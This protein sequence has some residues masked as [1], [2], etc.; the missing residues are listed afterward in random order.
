[1]NRKYNYFSDRF[2]GLEE[3]AKEALAKAYLIR[4]KSWNDPRWTEAYKE[5]LI[6]TDGEFKEEGI[7]KFRSMACFYYDR[8]KTKKG[9]YLKKG[10]LENTAENEIRSITHGINR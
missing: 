7:Q 8:I 5:G 9:D 2:R 1:M 10:W 3:P 4:N 6:A